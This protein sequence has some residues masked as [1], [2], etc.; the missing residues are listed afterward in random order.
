MASGQG[1]AYR[2]IRAGTGPTAPGPFAAEGRY[3]VARSEQVR[4]T[5]VVRFSA[6]HRYHSDQLSEAENQRVFGKC[7]RVHG[8]GHDYRLEVAVEGGVDP[9][10]G[11]VMNLA[12]LDELLRTE[13][14]EPL[15]HS[16]LNYD[17]P[18]FATVVP[19]CENLALYVM[20]R[21]RPALAGIAMRLAAVRVWE[22]DDLYAEV[23]CR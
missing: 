15:D 18:H 4:I 6:A 2:G 16:F 17:V 11:M 22:G 14:V 5:R 12:T 10:T 3:D 7:N 9:I 19:T 1:A 13:I 20:E 8:H 23:E 21:M